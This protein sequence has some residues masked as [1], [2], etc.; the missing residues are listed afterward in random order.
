[1]VMVTMRGERG[2]EKGVMMLVRG[3]RVPRRC[4][5]GF[6][7]RRSTFWWIRRRFCAVV[8]G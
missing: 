6:A 2:F 5:N 4:R 3:A 7:N 1:M 8:A